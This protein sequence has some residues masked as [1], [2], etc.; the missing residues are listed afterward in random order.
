MTASGRSGHLT[1][2]GCSGPAVGKTLPRLWSFAGRQRPRQ[3]E[4]L[5]RGAVAVSKQ[6]S[7]RAVEIFRD[8]LGRRV[9]D[10]VARMDDQDLA[11]HHLALG[12]EV[13]AALE[14]AL[15]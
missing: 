12:T 9:D 13:D 14:A 4:P 15:E 10:A 8:A 1:A 2:R 11:H 7:D 3:I 5:A 6:P